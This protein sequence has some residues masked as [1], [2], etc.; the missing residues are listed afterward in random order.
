MENREGVVCQDLRCGKLD[1]R[2]D[3]VAICISPDGSIR[4]AI[5]CIDRNGQGV[6]LVTDAAQRLLGVITDGDIRRAI[7]AGVGLSRTVAELLEQKKR[8]GFPSAVTIPAGTDRAGMLRAMRERGI[9]QIPVLD[10]ED[11]VVD[12][13]ILDELLP[14]QVLP[15]GAV[16]MAGGLGTRLRPLTEDL[17]K[18]MLPVGDRPLME[19][20]IEQLRQSG[21]RQM[22]VTTHYKPEKIV[23]HFGD[24]HKFG[25]ELNYVT[26]D[27]PLGTAGALGLLPVST[28]PLLVINGDILTRV[29]FRAMLAF[30]QE[31]N[32][33]LTVAVRQFDLNCTI[34]GA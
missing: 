6:A 23:E 28:Q 20:M 2:S 17:P 24:G 11:R 18:P 29:D 30:H 21:I 12:L 4:D 19:R 14:D 32:A 10:Q 26:E 13:V 31:Q 5:A 1:L 33:A 8:L 9:R 34:R 3:I 22:I 27:A 7:L 16:I 25:V 15:L